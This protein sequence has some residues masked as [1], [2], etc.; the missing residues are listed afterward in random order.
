MTLKQLI[1]S[2]HWLNIKTTLFEIFPEEKRSIS[3]YE[4]VFENLRSIEP[5]DFEFE[6]VLETN[7]I[8]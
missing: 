6:I 5:V 3:A 4:I 8:Q 7:M 2:N 1:Q